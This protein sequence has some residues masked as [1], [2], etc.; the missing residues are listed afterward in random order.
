M[1]IRNTIHRAV[2]VRRFNDCRAKNVTNRLASSSTSAEGP[3]PTP[4]PPSVAA[5]KQQLL[6]R[7]LHHVHQHGWTQEAIIQAIMEQRQQRANLSLSMAGLVT[8][9][10]LVCHAMDTFHRRL[11]HDLQGQVTDPSETPSDRMTR[12]IQLRLGYQREFMESQTW[13]Q[14]MALGAS[15]ENVM[16]TQQQLKRLVELIYQYAYSKGSMQQ[17]NQFAKLTLG[18]IYMATEL[19][20]LT[21]TSIDYTDTWTFLKQ[22]IQEWNQAGATLQN[23]LGPLASTDTLYVTSAVASAFA[24]GLASLLLPTAMTASSAFSSSLPNMSAMAA[25]PSQVP[26]QMY[27]SVTQTKAAD[28]NLDATDPRFYKVHDDKLR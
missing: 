9:K 12:A 15:P 17:S 4:K 25:T 21:D 2:I 3:S 28:D 27:D 22:R 26:N 18:G 8:P 16:H 19:H 11:E 7:S 6:E 20:M 13:H 1:S 24:S 23:T 5:M 14:A 10:D